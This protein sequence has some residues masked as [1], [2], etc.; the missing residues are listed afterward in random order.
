MDKEKEYAYF[1]E[2]LQE[3]REEYDKISSELEDEKLALKKLKAYINENYGAMDVMEL[4]ENVNYANSYT[5]LMEGDFTKKR[6]LGFLAKNPYFGKILF[7]PQG[8]KEIPVYIGTAGFWSTKSNSP[9]IYDWRAPICSMFYEYEPGE[10]SY[11]IADTTGPV[12]EIITHNG[13]ILEKCQ[14]KTEDG[15]LVYMSDTD[16]RVSDEL[17]LEALSGESAGR[18]KPVVATIQKEQNEII[19]DTTSKILVVDGRAGSGKTVVAMHR[20]AWLLYNR[21][22]TL[23][24]GNVFVISPN[25]VFSDYVSGIMP[26]LCED[27]VPSRQWD[28]IVD[29][30][31]LFESEHETKA[32]QA[33][34]ILSGPP[35]SLRSY[36]IALK[37]SIAFF[38]ALEAYIDDVFIRNIEFRDFHYEKITFTAQRLEK[39]FYGNFS[40][41]PAYE[42]FYNIAYFIMDEYVTEAKRNFGKERCEKIQ[43]NIQRQLISRFAVADVTQIYKDFLETVD[44]A[45]PGA[46]QYS[47]GE[48]RVCYE[49]LQVLFYLQLKL[50]GAK[51]YKDIKHVVIDEMQDYSVF[52][53]AAMRCLFGCSMTILGDRFQVLTKQEDVLTA[54][55]KIF[56]ERKL[57]VLATSY[58]QTVEINDFCNGFLLEEAVSVP[59]ARHGEAPYVIMC[60][61]AGGQVKEIEKQLDRYLE[62]GF[63][64]IAVLLDDEGSA[65]GLYREL[66]GRMVFL[67]EGNAGYRGGVCCMSRFIA[68]G[69]E[70]D[71]VIVAT[72]SNIDDLR[73]NNR[74]KGAFYISCTRAIHR[75]SVIGIK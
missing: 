21:K 46:A 45:F 26:E 20:L 10:A 28:D 58:R 30:I 71:A 2:V 47:D 38:E 60:D 49:D 52:Q 18:M 72:Q 69:M 66:P 55:T 43:L 25:T 59:F 24:T 70:F 37:T 1:E 68:K 67:T 8:K 40:S 50:Y 19:R 34:V 9:K 53:Y 12:T 61:D 35:D 31:M 6:N 15:R 5:K 22:K 74:E 75:L 57:R 13:E 29:E 54:I 33:D 41:L 44:K 48:G 65:Y 14:Y 17:L 11:S 16:V 4:S 62:E 32:M 56:P 7:K 27:N 3:I 39:M 64:N 36:N 51:S 23:N 63:K 42:R 73:E